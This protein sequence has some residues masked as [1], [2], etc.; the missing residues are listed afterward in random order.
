M[1]NSLLYF[2]VKENYKITKGIRIDLSDHIPRDLETLNKRFYLLPEGC[3]LQIDKTEEFIF[4]DFMG[5]VYPLIS[6][7]FREV[8]LLFGIE[9]FTKRVVLVDRHS[10]ERKSYYLLYT[11]TLFTA[12][13]NTPCKAVIDEKGKLQFL[14]NLVY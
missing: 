14:V 12:N 6:E 3:V 7:R 8:L 9:I 5:S 1:E 4:P 10:R 2:Y 13:F 11:D